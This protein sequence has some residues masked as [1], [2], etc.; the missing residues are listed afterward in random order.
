MEKRVLLTRKFITMLLALLIVIQ[1]GCDLFSLKLESTS[2]TGYE[3][4]QSD[5][6]LF[7]EFAYLKE[8]MFL[9]FLNYTW[10]VPAGRLGTLSMK[11]CK[12]LVDIAGITEKESYV[13]AAQ[14]LEQSGAAVATGQSWSAPSRTSWQSFR[15]TE[16]RQRYMVV[17]T[18]VR[19]K[20]AKV[21]SVKDTYDWGGKPHEQ[22]FYNR[23]PIAHENT[24]PADGR[25]AGY[26]RSYALHD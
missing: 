18:N 14:Q 22:E 10:Q 13:M 1:Q 4:F 19:T 24:E 21:V 11:E 5:V 6:E 2:D 23:M 12:R 26:G 7:Y 17:Y 16:N 9:E 3:G 15:H 8:A 20:M 25:Y